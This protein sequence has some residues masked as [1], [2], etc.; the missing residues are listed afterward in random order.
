MGDM[1]SLS[2]LGRFALFVLV[3]IVTEIKQGKIQH[4][5]LSLEQENGNLPIEDT[6]F[7]PG[8]L[9]KF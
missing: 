5:E 6:H 3:I 4:F 2:L 7:I 8:K 9:L 1:L